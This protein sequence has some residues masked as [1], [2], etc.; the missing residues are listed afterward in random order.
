MATPIKYK[1]PRRLNVVS[2]PL[3]ALLALGIYFAYQ[4]VPLFFLKH[5]AYR[6]LEETGSTFHGY[7]GL[8]RSDARARE[9]LRRKMESQLRAVGIDDP[10]LETWIDVEPG[11]GRVGALYSKWVHWPFEVLPRREV[12]Y[13]IEHSF[14]L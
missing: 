11:E 9:L 1:P 7:K 3:F 6:V 12:V 14:G 5:E 8:Y 13:E 10:D 4:Y 2:V